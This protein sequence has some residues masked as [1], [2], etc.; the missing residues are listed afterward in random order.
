MNSLKRKIQKTISN[1]PG[2]RTS[3][4]IVVIEADDWGSVR[5]FNKEAFEKM[6]DFGLHV[7]AFHY[8][9]VESLESNDD[10][11]T[12]FDFLTGFK[13]KNGKHPVI[14]AMCNTGNPDFEKIVE[15]DFTSYFFQ[16]LHETIKEYPKHDKLIELWKQGFNEGLFVPEIHGREHVNVRR[17]MD[18]L[19]NHEGK[20]GLRYAAKHKS[21]GVYAYKNFIYPNY[22]GALHPDSKEEIA[23]LH[24]YLKHSGELFKTYMGYNPS[25]FIAPNAEEPKELEKT[26]D[27]IGVKYLT[28][29]KKRVYPVGDG[30]FVKEW[31]FIG[32]KNEFGQIVINRNCFFEPVCWGESQHITDWVDYCLKDV[33]SAFSW[34]KPAV[35]CSH[36]VNYVGFIDPKN[37]DK[38]LQALHK[39]LSAILKK[40]PDVEFMSSAQLGD[41]IRSKK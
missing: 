41:T 30:A 12:L 36:R 4:K 20:E 35:I 39:L 10:L 11:H 7:E 27:S 19:Q 15:S 13:D 40:W 8:D 1:I 5:L 3:R 28:R 17:Y 6:R 24:S 21:M 9:S 32:K 31:N 38:G 33:E 26:L 34:K 16:P 23:E 29:S 22:L 18:I 2:W 37:R 25:V 14:T